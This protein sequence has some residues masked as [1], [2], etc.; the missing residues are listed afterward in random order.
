MDHTG[1]V[2]FDEDAAPDEDS[3]S[4]GS[5]APTLGERVFGERGARLHADQ[6]DPAVRLAA[7]VLLLVVAGYFLYAVVRLATH[8]GFF[9]DGFG[10]GLTHPVEYLANRELPYSVGPD[11]AIFYL[12]AA[13][14][15]LWS[16]CLLFRNR[17]IAAFVG[18]VT[19]VSVGF[20]AASTSPTLLMPFGDD[21]GIASGLLTGD[22]FVAALCAAALVGLRLRTRADEPH[23]T[24]HAGIEA[25]RFL[26]VAGGFT[27]FAAALFDIGVGVEASVRIG[28]AGI[29]YGASG[30][31]L[32]VAAALLR[33]RARLP[34]L[35]VYVAAIAIFATTVG[36]H[37]HDRNDGVYLLPAE[38][39][40][41]VLALGAAVAL[42][43]AAAWRQRDAPYPQPEDVFVIG[44]VIA[45]AV[46]VIAGT[47]LLPRDLPTNSSD[48]LTP[49][50]A[51]APAAASAT[52]TA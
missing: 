29:M 27:C 49:P 4:S 9:T 8:A 6:V 32:F 46:A 2:D 47:L 43:T 42:S 15:C 34:Y 38:G 44:I 25:A 21:Y 30:V 24:P 36:V 23:P 35:L 52:A 45:L 7:G 31:A 19:A 18:S 13:V 22:A 40:P 26:A 33:S 48:A 3:L 20:G 12:V 11:F 39:L 1:P 14:V 16:A 5:E 28:A 10:T 51:T 50:T 41:L 37:A 17:P